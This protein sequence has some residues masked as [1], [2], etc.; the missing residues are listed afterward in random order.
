MRYS[1][2]ENQLRRKVNTVKTVVH[3]DENNVKKEVG[4]KGKSRNHARIIW[5][6][7]IKE[8]ILYKTGRG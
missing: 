3:M 5:K 1:E 4:N 7:K 2:C 8:R 6:E